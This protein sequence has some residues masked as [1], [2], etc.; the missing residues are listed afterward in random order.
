ML[1]GVLEKFDSNGKLIQETNY[2][3]DFAFDF[4]HFIKKAKN[5]FGL[6]LNDEKFSVNRYIDD[7]LPVYVIV[8]EY[9]TIGFKFIKVDGTNGNIIFNKFVPRTE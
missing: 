6:D 4:T 5:E 7:G 3:K 2:D 8:Y 1:L 9:N